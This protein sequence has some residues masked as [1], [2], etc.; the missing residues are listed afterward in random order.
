MDQM[1]ERES[2]RRH[3]EVCFCYDDKLKSRER[4]QMVQY[5]PAALGQWECDEWAEG[6]RCRVAEFGRAAPDPAPQAFPEP[7]P[8]SVLRTLSSPMCSQLVAASLQ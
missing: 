4:G 3:K 2:T 1:E 8:T 6:G 5:G 7:E